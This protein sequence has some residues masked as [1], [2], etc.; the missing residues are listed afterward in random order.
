MTPGGNKTLLR[1][2]DWRLTRGVSTHFLPR[3]QEHMS[4]CILTSGHAVWCGV[5]VCVRED[6]H[7]LARPLPAAHPLPL[8]TCPTMWLS[9]LSTM[10]CG[11][12]ARRPSSA[13]KS[14]SVMEREH[15]WFSPSPNSRCHKR[16]VCSGATPQSVLKRY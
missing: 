11:V 8:P 3:C 13:V 6:R 5:R 2:S 9:S 1:E 7:L 12:S 10:P 14:A 16:F 15:Q 4:K